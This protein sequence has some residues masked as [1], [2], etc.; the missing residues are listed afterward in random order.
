MA[1]NS[2]PSLLHDFSINNLK[3][4]A[5]F[6]LFK[7]DARTLWQASERFPSSFGLQT[8]GNCRAASKQRSTRA[9]EPNAFHFALGYV[10]PYLGKMSQ[11]CAVVGAN[12]QRSKAVTWLQVHVQWIVPVL[13]PDEAASYKSDKPATS[14]LPGHRLILTSIEL[15]QV[16]VNNC[17]DLRAP[18]NQCQT[19]S[20]ILQMRIHSTLF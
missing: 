12:Q 10:K 17:R 14:N 13:V 20:R 15:H 18:R 1:T 19:G 7:F 11:I 6:V 2:L 4:D 3:F 9:K 8:W 5:R 16:Y